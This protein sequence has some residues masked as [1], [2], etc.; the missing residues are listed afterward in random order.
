[1]AY[2]ANDRQGSKIV[3]ASGEGVAQPPEEQRVVSHDP[4]VRSPRVRQFLL[5]VSSHT[6]TH[7][8]THTR[9]H[10]R[11]ATLTPHACQS[12]MHLW[13]SVVAFR[14]RRERAW[15]PLWRRGSAS[16][17]STFHSAD[18][19]LLAL[20]AIPCCLLVS[21]RAVL[22]PRLPRLRPFFYIRLARDSFSSFRSRY[23]VSCDGLPRSRRYLAIAAFYCQPPFVVIGCLFGKL[24]YSAL[25]FEDYLLHDC[26]GRDILSLYPIYF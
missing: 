25:R 2:L 16:F 8:H 13:F 5:F 20:P 11:V 18:S 23:F 10:G 6:L 9:T 19:I 12:L 17:F 1:M 7:T 26:R 4:S 24:L 21:W 3:V 15:T 22:G 14:R